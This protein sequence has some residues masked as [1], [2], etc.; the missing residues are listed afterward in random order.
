MFIPFC[1]AVLCIER[2][3]DAR[4]DFLRSA[5]I[6][7]R[8]ADGGGPY[9]SFVIVIEQSSEFGFRETLRSES[10]VLPL[11]PAREKR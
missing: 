7:A 10:I 5:N 3:L 2:A 4:A 1:A 11:K 8:N 6:L 9:T